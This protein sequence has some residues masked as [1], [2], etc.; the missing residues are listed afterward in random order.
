MWKGIKNVIPSVLS[1]IFSKKRSPTLKDDD[2]VHDNE[3]NID[4][5]IMIKNEV[6]NSY[7]M[8]ELMTPKVNFKFQKSETVRLTMNE[9][10]EMAK[11]GIFTPV[12]RSTIGKMSESIVKESEIV[13]DENFPT[14]PFKF[15]TPAIR[16]ERFPSKLDFDGYDEN[17]VTPVKT[18]SFVES[19]TES[20]ESLRMTDKNRIPT[21]TPLHS[22]IPK[23][24]GVR[25]ERIRRFRQ[26]ESIQMEE[27][28][29]MPQ[30]NVFI[31]SETYFENIPNESTAYV[32]EKLNLLTD[33]Y[34]YNN[35]IVKDIFRTPIS[36]D[37]LNKLLNGKWID[38]SVV[39]SMLFMLC[40]CG[41]DS[42]RYDT[43][44]F[45]ISH[46][47]NFA[48]HKIDE[49]PFSLPANIEP[50]PSCVA[51][52]TFFYPR[53]RDNGIQAVERY[54]QRQNIQNFDKILIPIHLGSHWT[55]LV[56]NLR[57]KVISYFDSLSN[58]KGTAKPCSFNELFNFNMDFGSRNV[59][60]TINSWVEYSKCLENFGNFNYVVPGKRCPQ[61]NN[62][63]DCGLFLLAFAEFFSLNSSHFPFVKPK[64]DPNLITPYYRQKLLHQLL[65]EQLLFPNFYNIMVPLN[66]NSE[67]DES[68]PDM[69]FD[70][71]DDD[72][73]VL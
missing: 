24:S 17:F 55:L 20:F 16:K 65:L 26:Q 70:E 53:L 3:F 64:F 7:N 73:I 69:E 12:K 21:I 6:K 46:P 18:S 44:K 39:N 30:R 57:F 1:S 72:L 63:D 68:D 48:K 15:M 62:Y 71:D 40:T 11:K 58:F 45:E 50:I 9:R 10:R 54:V 47:T 42:N 32:E 22:T 51:F 35:Y 59:I 36:K 34:V 67:E 14:P 60:Q 19:R 25:S 41:L 49:S 61:Q 28:I 8:S 4:S 43:S 5:K 13:N 38:D 52:N 33:R 31:P 37:S 29:Y 56:I 23:Y 66:E 2:S 27:E